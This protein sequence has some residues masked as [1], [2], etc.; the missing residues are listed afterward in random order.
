MIII[1]D[2][3]DRENEGDLV[4]AAELVT[5]EI[6][7]FMATHG[8]GL[9]CLPMTP[10]RLD[11]LEIPLMVKENTARRGTAFCVSIEARREITTKTSHRSLTITMAEALK[12]FNRS[13][14]SPLVRNH[15]SA[16]FKAARP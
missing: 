11:E 10:E 4:C 7:N 6:V 9:I 2:D 1:L 14:S 16:C 12:E 3:E 15:H 5:P 8:R 13:P